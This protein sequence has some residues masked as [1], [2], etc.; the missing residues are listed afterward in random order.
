MLYAEDACRNLRD[1]LDGLGLSYNINKVEEKSVEFIVNKNG[2]ETK[3]WFDVDKQIFGFDMLQGGCKTYD[4]FSKFEDFFKT[5]MS[6]YTEFLPSAK[7][8]ADEFEK[9]VGVSSIYD[10]F[11]G[12]KQTGY[13]AQFKVLGHDNKIILISKIPQGFTAKFGSY[14]DDGTKFKTIT[15]YRYEV[16]DVNNVTCIPT[17][18]SYMNELGERYGSD[19][20]IDIERIGVDEFSFTIEGLNILAKIEIMYKTITYEV[21]KIAGVD[22]NFSCE[23]EDD[24]YKLSTLYMICKDKYDDI[25]CAE[26]AEDTD[27]TDDTTEDSA[28]EEDTT[29]DS[30]IEED[31]TEDD[32]TEEDAIEDTTEDDITEENVTDTDEVEVKQEEAG[33]DYPIKI[34]LGDKGTAESLQFMTDDAI[35]IMSAEKAREL[36]IP[37]ERIDVHATCVKKHGILITE[38][39]LQRKCFAKNISYDED[40]CQKLFID[41]F[42]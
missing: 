12:N 22:V 34:I 4:D 18:H 29:E 3:V 7:A 2:I 14:V 23:L 37:I 35:Y 33:V 10:T 39:E 25:I 8:V 30:T 31:T 17:I 24:P 13:T 28:T 16:D 6:I 11:Q 21:E 27:A 5:Y 32:I 38:D 42:A 9:V 41:I 20:S 19:D 1:S 15:E 26:E 36:G 40:F